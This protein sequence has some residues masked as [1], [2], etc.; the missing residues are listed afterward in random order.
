MRARCSIAPAWRGV[1]MR[2][3]SSS[4]T[5]FTLA[6]TLV[7]APVALAQTPGPSPAFQATDTN[8]DG[9]IDRAEYHNRLMDAFFLLDQDKDGY[10]TPQELPH[11]AAKDFR[12]ADSDLDLKLSAIEY[13]NE[14][15]KEFSAADKNRDGILSHVEVE[16]YDGF[17][18]R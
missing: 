1:L 18:R 2:R 5:F 8:G 14:R 17:G 6:V 4:S 7:F 9:R 11:V 13:I 15:F 10:L 12:A 3:L 16:E